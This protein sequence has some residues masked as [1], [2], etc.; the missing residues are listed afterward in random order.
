MIANLE[1]AR[2]ATAG[3]VMVVPLGAIVRAPGGPEGYAVYLVLEE[4][5]AHVA[6]LR[7]VEL[8]EVFGNTIAVS[9]GVQPGDRVV[10]AGAT[11]VRDGERVRLVP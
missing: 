11:I 10:V 8:D 5:G 7:R 2:R 4:E 3:P 9:A 6:R 1:L